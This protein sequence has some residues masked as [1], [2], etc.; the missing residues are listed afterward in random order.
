MS[1]DSEPLVVVTPNG[2]YCPPGDFY[3]D[4]WQ[5]VQTAVITHAH[6]DHLRHGSTRYILARPGTGIARQRLGGERELA[7]VEYRTPM[8]L[9]ATTVSLHPA[10]HILGS[11]QVRIEH[12]GRV[13]VVS[14][15][16]KRQPD[17]TCAPF[18]PVECDVFISEA[19]FALP[20]YRWPDTSRVVEEIHR[21]WNANRER[22]TASVL[23]CYAL[24]KA[25]RV[26]AELGAFTNEPVYLH[27]AVDSL[28]GVYRRAGVAML[29]TLPV[30]TDKKTDFRG[31]LIIAP[32]NAAGTPWMRRFGEHASGFCSG[33]MRVRGDRRRRGYDRG[34]VISDHADWPALIET[35]T[36]SRAKR[37]L[38]THGYSDALTRYF[39]EKG[40][41]AGAL[42]T[43][44]GDEN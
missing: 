38:L 27:G 14:G 42:K 16:Y 25:Q 10:G 34:F 39:N 4:P 17:P 40:V 18:E 1:S 33:W 30:G 9:G 15:D 6:G 12:Q 28:T 2:L 24:G 37:L 7:P 35:C 41:A 13:W 31:A 23:F 5:P 43:S 26:L 19:T 36:A 32:P 3:V 8:S 22:G 21:W 44:F 11:S 29:P 20:V